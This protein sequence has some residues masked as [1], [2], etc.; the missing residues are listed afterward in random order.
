MVTFLNPGFLFGFLA[1][2]IP[3]FLHLMNRQVPLRVRFPS[4]RFL[5]RA[6]LPQEGHRRLRDLLLLLFRLLLLSAVLCAFARPV[7]RP[8]SAA[9]PDAGLAGGTT[10]L[11]LDVSASTAGWDTL[12]TEKE[13][14]L[15]ALRRAPPEQLIGLV[16][17]GNRTE[18]AEKPTRDRKRIEQAIRNATAGLI[19]GNHGEALAAAAAFRGDRTPSE[20][21]VY[22]DFQR[23]DWE[24]R[25][26]AVLPPAMTL[27]LVECGG[28]NR[29][30]AGIA[31]VS[32]VPLKDE[33][34]RL[35]VDVRNYSERALVREVTAHLG[36]QVQTATV[37]LP[38]LTSRRTAFVVKRGGVS[39]AILRLAPDQYPLDDEY[40]A[41]I[42]V[43]PPARILAILP[44]QQEPGKATEFFFLKKLL[45]VP[46]ES[47]PFRFALEQAETEFLFA[48]NLD[49][50]QAVFLLGAAGYLRDAGFDTLLEYLNR[51]GTVILT[52]G[53]AA[54]HGFNGLRRRGMLPARYV[55]T[56]GENEKEG[57]HFG[58]GW[59]NPESL[60]GKTFANPAE[61]DLFL[62]AIR[63]YIRFL[64]EP[65]MTVLLKTIEGDPA[66]VEVGIGKGRLFAWAFAFEPSWG[67]LPMTGS[68]LPIIRE[69]LAPAVAAGRGVVRIPCGG[70]LPPLK[71]LYGK[72][73]SAQE[74]ENEAID[75]S[76]P[77]A[78]AL[79]EW[80]VEVNVSRR[81]SVTETANLHDVK[82]ALSQ[83]GESGD[84]PALA[85]A[86]PAG[87]KTVSLW[88][89][90]ARAAAL[91]LVAEMLF[92]L[93]L[94]RR[95]TGPGNTPPEPGPGAVP[96]RFKTTSDLEP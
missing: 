72:N 20:L 10:V 29:E 31:G 65:G 91:L 79:G 50:V 53:N 83:P 58:L 76:S 60:L 30:N 63:K 35:V 19:E 45:S 82:T 59:V 92:A 7:W 96:I 46:D 70:P 38:P 52:P 67:D 3:V 39:R 81:E 64:P 5:R 8:R 27:T 77:G 51:G 12:A 11:F 62:F 86:T 93:F 26:E 89:F 6:Q 40:H 1:L 69:L 44:L 48:L 84:R 32:V 87:E 23:T 71:D 43:L 57:G 47:T 13:R 9:A 15:A 78:F 94:D 90:F 85:A 4:I 61:T 56:A 74:P 22:S 55:G 18:L 21:I 42:G 16:I 14:A 75:L 17:S 41:W 54:A 37:D 28:P 33:T 2:G 95:A 80:P 36:E 25:L 49:S 68:F 73:V 34:V 66:L 88:P 24:Q